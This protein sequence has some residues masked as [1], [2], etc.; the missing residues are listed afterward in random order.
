MEITI[1]AS[2]DHLQDLVSTPL[3]LGNQSPQLYAPT[4]AAIPCQYDA[5]AQEL[6]W[7]LEE[8]LAAGER[9]TYRVDPQASPS[10]AQRR[11]RIEEK[12]D[13][14]NVYAGEDHFT[15]YTFLGMRRPYFW[16][17]NG[18]HGSIVRGAGTGDHPHHYGL[19]IAYGGHGE[20]G[21]T[22]IWSDWDEE[23]YGPCGKVIHRSFD[24]LVS[25]DVYAEIRQTLWYL[26]VNGDIIAEEKRRI[27]LWQLNLSARFIDWQ[28]DLT[29][30]DDA[31]T[32]PF[33]FAA[34]LPNHITGATGHV[35]NSEGVVGQQAART[36]TK[37]CDFSGPLGDGWAGLAFFDHPENPEHPGTFGPY[38]VNPQMTLCHHAPSD[39]GFQL[40]FRAYVHE[41]KTDEAEVA[42]RYQD[43][44]HPVTVETEAEC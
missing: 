26:K 31:G 20:G 8:P 30:P 21:S 6:S 15:R 19:S 42:G 36:E 28:V 39:G 17:V 5:Q 7:I 10:Q 29:E 12:A 40:Q 22:N 32:K 23:P 3:N 34:R 9:R 44:I 2:Q 24:A 43:F 38:A 13:H 25:G 4:G 27:R 35:E 33:M 41:G 37:W 11:M 14:L 1:V 18:P 16:P